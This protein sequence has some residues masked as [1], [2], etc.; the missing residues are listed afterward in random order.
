MHMLSNEGII[1]I[2]KK[3]FIKRLFCKHLDI[4][5]GESCSSMGLMRIS[6]QDIITACK[7]CG[8]IINRQSTNY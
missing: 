7:K 3:S 8:T 4:I 6:G 1:K 5:T 2:E